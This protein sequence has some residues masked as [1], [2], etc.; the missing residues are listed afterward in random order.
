[1]DKVQQNSKFRLCGDSEETINHLISKC[2]KLAHR[3]YKTIQ[4]DPLGIVQE[5]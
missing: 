4:G 3:E 1:M 5:V 2:S